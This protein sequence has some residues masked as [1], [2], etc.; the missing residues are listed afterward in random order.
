MRLL[1][2]LPCRQKGRV[3]PCQFGF[4]NGR[5]AGLT[6]SFA[7][8]KPIHAGGHQQALMIG[9]VPAGQVPRLRSCLLKV[10]LYECR[11]ALAW[12]VLESSGLDFVQIAVLLDFAD[13]GA[14][15]RV[16]RRK[17]D[18]TLARWLA[19]HWVGS[20]LTV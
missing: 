9:S 15:T 13:T 20:M 1:S 10:L 11:S 8:R 5:N 14:F 12:Q 7:P 16:F 19:E 6:E 2:H 18:A 17:S 3:D 4:T